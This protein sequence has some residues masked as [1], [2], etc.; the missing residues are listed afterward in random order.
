M[1]GFIDQKGNELALDSLKKDA[2]MKQQI[3][4]ELE[5]HHN[6]NLVKSLKEQIDI[7]LSEVYFFTRRATGKKNLFK[8]LMKSKI[9]DNKCHNIDTNNQNDKI[10]ESAPS[11][12]HNQ[13]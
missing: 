8:I 6:T 2:E 7:L 9:S 3:S 13:Y 4:Q 12:Y 5:A 11:V 1:E 10:S